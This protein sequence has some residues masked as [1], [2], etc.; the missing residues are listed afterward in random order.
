MSQAPRRLTPFHI[1]LQVRD[2]EEARDF[3]GR[4]L[5]LPE[6][7]SSAQ[8][9]DF[10]LFGHQF[11]VHHNPALGRNGRVQQGA[12]AVDSHGVPVPHCGVVL[13]FD[14]WEA[15]AL[16]LREQVDFTVEPHVRFRGQPGEQGTL[17]F[18]D[19]SGNALEF[20]GFRDIDAELFRKD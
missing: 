18:C 16:R 6:G 8:W 17:F 11:V 5:G 4:R 7:R 10:D 15:L 1:A 3:Y 2:L 12:S 19:P 13:P 9:I 20:K 14:E